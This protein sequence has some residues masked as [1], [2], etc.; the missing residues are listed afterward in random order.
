[1]RASE[2]D[3]FTVSRLNRSVRELIEGHF[4]AVW[5]E[6]ELSNLARPASGHWY[7]TL[8]DAGAQV[9]CAMFRTRNQHLGFQPADGTQV[10]AYARVGMYEPRGEYQLIVEQLEPA[11]EGLLR[12]KLEALKRKLAAEG[13]F[14]RDR[15]RALPA[16]PHRIGVITS[17]TGAAVR[18]VL[19]VLHRRSPGIPV[20]VYPT[21]VQGAAAAPEIVR[22]LH[23]AN[24]RAE[25]AVLIMTRG[26]GSLEDLWA[27]N[28][29]AVVRAVCDSAIPIV[30]AIGHEIDFTLTD[31]AADARAATPSA[32]A[33]IC[34]PDGI[35]TLRAVGQMERR[36][37]AAIKQQLAVQTRRER[38]LRR[39]LVH[40]GRR[41]EEAYQRVDELSR[42]LP[43]AV[44][45]ALRLRSA[46]LGALQAGLSAHNP[47]RVIALMAER[48]AHHQRRLTA[49]WAARATVLSARVDNSV[50]ALRTVSP[51]ATLERGYAIVSDGSGN[52]L[53]EAETTAVG[54]EVN[55]RLARGQLVCRI[56]DILPPTEQRN[57]RSFVIPRRAQ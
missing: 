29:E 28:E 12:L 8:K 6:G 22:A 53:R 20:I 57:Q 41:I 43:Q 14:D 55:A 48:L 10:L 23:H 32:A 17:P 25:C 56:E 13:L 54:A 19:T 51:L 52:I 11:G 44:T 35:E 38:D 49:A 46:R 31:F 26:G 30:S 36:L 18:D 4:G 24:R 47:Q 3:I 5:V 33:E 2:R 7:F 34:S 50:R 42:R 40:P 16:W 39:R 1:M 27:F 15:K 37:C 9:R 21:A 45:T